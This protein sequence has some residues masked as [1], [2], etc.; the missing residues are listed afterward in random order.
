[1]LK[2]QKSELRKAL[3]AARDAMSAAAR[4]GASQF[5]VEKI[6]A[7]PACRAARTV[8][9]YC[10]FGSEL[11][12]RP[13]LDA[14]LAAGK[15][16]VLPRVDQASKSID[17]YRVADLAA[18]LQAGKWGILEPRADEE[19]RV[20]IGCVDFALVPGVGF[21]AQCHR[22]GYGA[23]FYDRLFGAAQNAGVKL[24]RRV[25]GAF[26][27]Q[28]AGAIPVGDCDLPV[29]RVVTENNDYQREPEP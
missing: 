14:T 6:A 11:D 22:L 9:A 7:D 28:I 17:L 27:C 23:G 19:L 15:I 10:S 25:A 21:D 24:P 12:T 5:I 4:N 1:M 16:L 8:M 2:E 20:A 13:F 26:S 18:D 3:V 29:D